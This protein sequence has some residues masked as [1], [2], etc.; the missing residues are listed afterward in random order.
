MK[1]RAEIVKDLDDILNIPDPHMNFAPRVYDVLRQTR[2]HLKNLNEVNQDFAY[3]IKG[4]SI[5]SDY[6]ALTPL[7]EYEKQNIVTHLKI[8]KIIRRS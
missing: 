7:T 3:V 4:N 8:G 5:E 1:S 6:L 2:E